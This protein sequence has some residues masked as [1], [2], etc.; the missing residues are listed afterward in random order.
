MPRV[1][2]VCHG[3]ICRSP[4]AEFILKD[5]VKKSGREKDFWISSAA[6]S[7][8]E[9]GHDVY[10]PAQQILRQH[11]VPFTSRQ[12][13]QLNAEEYRSYDFFLGMDEE[14]LRNMH[15][16]F[17]S[18]PAHKIRLLLSFTQHPRPVA[19]P[20]YTRDFSQAYADIDEGCRAF[21][22]SLP[23]PSANV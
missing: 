13:R 15:R 6:T 9:I 19:D 10:P 8:E 16:L 20:W 17:K 21:L 5:L 23:F 22:A 7:R 11:G 12:A 4:M 2:F 1:L 18:D 14:N 3:N